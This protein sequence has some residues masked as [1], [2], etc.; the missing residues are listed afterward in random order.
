MTAAL[1]TH[2]NWL[3]NAW[4]LA[5]HRTLGSIGIGPL[6][7]DGQ[8][9]GSTTSFVLYLSTALVFANISF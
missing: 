4:N 3:G 1:T 9:I 2:R 7:V 6:V 8:K 5:R